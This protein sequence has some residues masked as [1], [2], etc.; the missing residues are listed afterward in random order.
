[1]RQRTR[2]QA[3]GPSFLLDKR[4]KAKISKNFNAAM[5]LFEQLR[6]MNRRKR[7]GPL[8]KIQV[9]KSINAIYSDL[10][11]LNR[12]AKELI[13]EVAVYDHF[14]NKYGLKKVAVSKCTQLVN[15][16]YQHKSNL[17]IQIFGKFAH[18]YRNNKGMNS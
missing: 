8:K 13:I 4:L 3:I 5:K 14:L 15:S 18:L 11:K 16:C 9:I 6:R 12:P 17:R 1:M 2:I 7:R 10:L